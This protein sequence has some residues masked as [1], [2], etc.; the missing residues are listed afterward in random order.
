MVSVAIADE[1]IPPVKVADPF[2][3]IHTG[4]SAGYPIV[5]VIERDAIITIIKKR[6][7][8]YLIEDER[9][10]EGWVH[11]SQLAKTLTLDDENIEIKDITHENYLNH[12]IEMSIWEVV[13]KT[14]L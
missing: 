13:L 12:D 6:T 3:E 4:P 5:Y 10:K 2:L 11:R 9:K 14:C 7:S 1:T 8:W